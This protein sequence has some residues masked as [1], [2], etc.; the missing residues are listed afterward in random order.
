MNYELSEKPNKKGRVQRLV[1]NPN[2]NLDRATARSRHV[3]EKSSHLCVFYSF[4]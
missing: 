3:T 4:S 2:A 1:R